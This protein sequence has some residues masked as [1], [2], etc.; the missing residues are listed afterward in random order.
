MGKAEAP[1]DPG[2]YMKTYSRW[3]Q[4]IILLLLSLTLGP[5]I[6]ALGSLLASVYPA[7]RLYFLQPI[8]AMRAA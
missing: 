5:A 3:L 1:G 2:G 4:I 7:L 8:E 6:V